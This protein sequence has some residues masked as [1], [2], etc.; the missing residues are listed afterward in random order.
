MCGIWALLSKQKIGKFGFL[1]DAFMQI[2][3]RGP[4]FSSFDLINPFVLLGFHRLGMGS[5]QTP[6][7]LL[8]V[9]KTL[10]NRKVAMRRLQ[11]C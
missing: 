1:Y 9:L 8:R 11:H 4:E 2:K 7:R 10:N 5:A 6:N 3:N